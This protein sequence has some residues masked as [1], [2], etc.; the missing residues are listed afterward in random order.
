MVWA[1]TISCLTVII[2]TDNKVFWIEFEFSRKNSREPLRCW[3]GKH[4]EFESW[5]SL[6]VEEN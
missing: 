2:A 1:K 6:D 4:S 5:F 3:M